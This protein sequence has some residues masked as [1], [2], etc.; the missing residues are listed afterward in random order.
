MLKHAHPI[1]FQNFKIPLI[2]QDCSHKGGSWNKFHYPVLNLLIMALLPDL[3][4]KARPVMIK[5]P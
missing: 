2:L 3:R 1:A 4:P 5:D